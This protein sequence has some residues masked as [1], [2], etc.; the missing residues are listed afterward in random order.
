MDIIEIILITLITGLVCLLLIKVLNIHIYTHNYKKDYERT[1]DA[2]S[3]LL[4]QYNKL[5][6]KTTF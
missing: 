4:I 1:I 6:Q 3:D 2:Y 5:K